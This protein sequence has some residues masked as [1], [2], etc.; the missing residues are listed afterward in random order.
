MIAVRVDSELIL[1]LFI[2]YNRISEVLFV[3]FSRLIIDPE[4]DIIMSLKKVIRSI[5][6]FS[7]KVGV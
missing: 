5:H 4:I 2:L 7:T 6:D 3:N 1:L